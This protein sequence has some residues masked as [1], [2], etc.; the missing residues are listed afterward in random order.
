MRRGSRGFVL[1]LVCLGLL[2]GAMTPTESLA[3]PVAFAEP[4]AKSGLLLIDGQYTTS[5]RWSRRLAGLR[6]RTTDFQPIRLSSASPRRSGLRSIRMDCR[7]ACL[8]SSAYPLQTMR[9]EWISL[10]RQ[11]RANFASTAHGRACF[12]QRAGSEDISS[13][14][15]GSFCVI[16]SVGAIGDA[17]SALLWDGDPG[18]G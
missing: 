16:A 15:K 18:L 12:A 13:G 17:A 6:T 3:E 5:R 11:R 14:A 4:W 10:K 8:G 2:G 1:F 7:S 9:P